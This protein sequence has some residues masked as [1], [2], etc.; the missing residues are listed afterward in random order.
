MNILAIGA[1][2]DD[3]EIFAYGFWPPPLRGDNLTLA[4]ATDGAAGGN[5]PGA[6]LAAK[7]ADETRNGLAKLGTPVLLGLPDGGLAG[8]ADARA[9]SPT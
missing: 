9:K 3:L 2:P 8:A 6:A 1:H 7:R 5:I 4:V